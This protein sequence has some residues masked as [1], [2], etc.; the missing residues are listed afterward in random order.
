MRGRAAEVRSAGAQ[1]IFV[2]NG[3]P[4]FAAH[5]KTRD[6]GGVD[7]YTDPSL[8]IYRQLGMKRG[9]GATLSPRTWAAAARATARGHI[10]TGIE[11]DPWQQGGVVVLARGGEIVYSRPNRDAGQRPRLDAALA[12][13]RRPATS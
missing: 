6:A 10:Q 3:S 7:V 1:L 12:A 11:G 2:G 8:A 4:A 5:F 9:V 13:L